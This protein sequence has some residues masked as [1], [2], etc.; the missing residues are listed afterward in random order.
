M[1]ESYRAYKGFSDFQ[2]PSHDWDMDYVSPRAR[3]FPNFCQTSPTATLEEEEAAENVY[4][5]TEN[6]VKHAETT[7]STKVMECCTHGN[8]QPPRR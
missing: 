6:S 8:F 1:D 2:C 4:E 3:H 7:C 5:A